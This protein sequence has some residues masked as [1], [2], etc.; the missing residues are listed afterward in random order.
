MNDMSRE[1]DKGN[2]W[3]EQRRDGCCDL[4]YSGDAA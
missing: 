3:I 1:D 2:D 4:I